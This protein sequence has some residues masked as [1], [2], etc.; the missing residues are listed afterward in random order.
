MPGAPRA[1]ARR[2]APSRAQASAPASGP[3]AR[4][5]A[6]SPRT[7]HLARAGVLSGPTRRRH[8]TATESASP[9]WIVTVSHEGSRVPR[10]DGARRR[11]ATRRAPAAP[12]WAPSRRRRR[13]RRT[14]GS[15]PAGRGAG[16][17]GGGGAATGCGAGATSLA[18]APASRSGEDVAAGTVRQSVHGPSVHATHAPPTH[19]ICLGGARR[20]RW[21]VPLGDGVQAAV[22]LVRQLELPGVQQRVHALRQ[23][24]PHTHTHTRPHLSEATP[25]TQPI[26]NAGLLAL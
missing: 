1:H 2:G 25:P 4:A 19:R 21:R 15:R 23:A 20:R 8:V 7:R 22:R 11:E 24:A 17:R 12:T 5:P 6:A 9:T 3:R 16:A 13:G 26:V 10:R 18:A 14:A